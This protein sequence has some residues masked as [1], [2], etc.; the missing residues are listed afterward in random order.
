[1]HMSNQVLQIRLLGG[2]HDGEITFIPWIMLSPSIRGVDF[3]IHLKCRQFPIQL[4]FAMTI[5]R[6][7]S[8]SVGHVAVDLHTPAFAHG[9]LYVAFS[10]VTASDK[11]KVLLPTDPPCQTTNVIYP[12]ILLQWHDLSCS[13]YVSHVAKCYMLHSRSA[14]RFS[15]QSLPLSIIDCEWRWRMCSIGYILAVLHVRI[16]LPAHSLVFALH[17]KMLHQSISHSIRCPPL[18]TEWHL[19]L[20]CIFLHLSSLSIFQVVP[21]CLFPLTPSN[22]FALSSRVG[23]EPIA[24]QFSFGSFPTSTCTFKFSL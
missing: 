8:Q 23:L 6:S 24:P 17:S 13:P 18:M 21:A 14:I 10:H 12:E 2:D 1:M 19:I 7:Q 3:T 22:E 15:H 11:I 9:Q 16:H 5:N 4:A 20:S